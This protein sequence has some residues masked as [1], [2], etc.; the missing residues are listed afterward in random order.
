MIIKVSLNYRET[1]VSQAIACM[2]HLR[3][4]VV[5]VNSLYLCAQLRFSHDTEVIERKFDVEN[6]QTIA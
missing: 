1:P 4:G 6:E 2:K 5:L 3:L